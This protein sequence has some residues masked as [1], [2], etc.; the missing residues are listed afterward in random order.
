[1]LAGGRVLADGA[2]QDVLAP[3]NVEAAYGVSAIVGSDSGLPYVIPTT[4]GGAR[5]S[6]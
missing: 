2:W 1:M 4:R 6:A 3:A 5:S